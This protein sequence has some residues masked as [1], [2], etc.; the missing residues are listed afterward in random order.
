MRPAMQFV[1]CANGYSAQIKVCKGEKCVDGKSIM[2]MTMLAATL[3]TQ[4]K[5]IAQG[6]DAEQAVEE[7]AKVIENETSEA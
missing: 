5:I 3:G 7:L 1:D 4:L 6:Q 2:Q